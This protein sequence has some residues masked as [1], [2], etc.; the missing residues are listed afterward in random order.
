VIQCEVFG[1]GQFAISE[2]DA[3]PK[4]RQYWLLSETAVEAQSKGNRSSKIA[5]LHFPRLL[6]APVKTFVF[7]AAAVTNSSPTLFS[8][9]NGRFHR[10]WD[11]PPGYSIPAGGLQL[12][13]DESHA[14]V[15]LSA[16]DH[17]SNNDMSVCIELA[18]RK[19]TMFPK[20]VEA[21]DYL[22]VVGVTNQGD[23][24]QE[25]ASVADTCQFIRRRGWQNPRPVVR[26]IREP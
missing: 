2:R 5:S 12:S 3:N 22:F 26:L 23:L 13:E 19:V 10:L 24:I 20:P 7:A 15:E 16:D 9:M 6:I 1:S 14:A 18:T 17:S 21:S 25:N 11:V 8:I 4:G